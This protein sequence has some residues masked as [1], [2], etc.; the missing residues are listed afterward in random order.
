M[1]EHNAPVTPCNPAKTIH[2]YAGKT[3]GGN[4]L[5]GLNRGNPVKQSKAKRRLTAM[6][7]ARLKIRPAD[8]R[9]AGKKTRSP[10]P[11]NSHSL[12]P[13]LSARVSG[14]SGAGHPQD[15]LDATRPVLKLTTPVPSRKGTVRF[16]ID[17]SAILLLN[18]LARSKPEKATRLPEYQLSGKKAGLIAERVRHSPI[19]FTN[20]RFLLRPSNSP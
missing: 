10:T 16:K 19:I 4:L 20:T 12:C 8:D 3:D 11:Q 17:R 6:R 2:D 5:T 14:S 13:R 15:W 18:D 1:A 9:I 7:S